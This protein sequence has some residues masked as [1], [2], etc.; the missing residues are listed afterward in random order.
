MSSNAK[1]AI[2]LL[3]MMALMGSIPYFSRKD[4]T[5]SLLESN[6]KLSGSQRQRGM[7]LMAGQ[8]D[9]GPD[10]N[11]DARTGTYTKYKKP[12]QVKKE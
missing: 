4:Q 9:A 10:P 6:K 7:N 2:G 3:G 5:E 1:V 12:V 11:Y 8:Q